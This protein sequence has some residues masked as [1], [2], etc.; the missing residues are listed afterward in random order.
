ML[1][2]FWLLLNI[3]LGAECVSS[4]M[5]RLYIFQQFELCVLISVVFTAFYRS[6]RAEEHWQHMLHE[7]CPPSPVELVR[8]L[9]NWLLI[10]SWPDRDWNR[11]HSQI[12]KCPFSGV[13]LSS[14]YFLNV[15][16]NANSDPHIFRLWFNFVLLSKNLRDVISEIK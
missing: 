12:S 1:V 13:C 7:R 10:L 6:D 4:M 2:Q 3:K 16:W 8:P 9:L 5:S 14:F 11:Q 15:I